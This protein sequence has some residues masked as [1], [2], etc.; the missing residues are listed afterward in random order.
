MSSSWKHPGRTGA[1]LYAVLAAVVGALLGV[2]SRLQVAKQRTRR[3]AAGALPAGP[4]IVISNHTSYADGLLLALACRRLGRTLRLLATSGVF[5]VPVIGTLARR[6]GF[7]PVRRGAADAA[8]SLDEAATALAHGEAVGLYPEGRL[9]RDP[10]MW[11]ERAKTGAV[12]L[13]LRSDAP[14]VPVAMLG[15]H[16]VVGRS[17]ILRNL[18]RNVI[19]R[20]KVTTRVG[21]PID[22]RELMRVGPTT[23]P[24]PDEIRVASDLMMGRLVD[25]VEELRGEA[26]PHPHGA[27]RI[28][29]SA[30]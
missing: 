22:V 27:P 24:T 19:R 30:A 6:L 8:A 7:I 3:R 28:D 18:I 5:R 9:T 13:A 10:M 23:E 21:A 2:F 12:R 29:D 4:I 16:E 17:A 14:I 26:A 20:P 15:A 1:L 11:P 25:L